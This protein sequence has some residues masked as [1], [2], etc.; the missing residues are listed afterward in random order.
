MPPESI[1]ALAADLRRA[2]RDTAPP[3]LLASAASSA[4]SASSAGAVPTLRPVEQ[5]EAIRVPP[6]GS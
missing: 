5:L 1:P 2:V 4:S 6:E 3:R